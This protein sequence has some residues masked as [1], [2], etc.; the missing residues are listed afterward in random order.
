MRKVAEKFHCRRFEVFPLNV[1]QN[2]SIYYE[3]KSTQF[4]IYGGKPFQKPNKFAE[5][6]LFI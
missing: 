1:L 3:L 5:A 2:I 4:N 6:L